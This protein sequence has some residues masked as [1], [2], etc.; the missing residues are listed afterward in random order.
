MAFGDR[1][2]GAAARALRRVTDALSGTAE[3]VE[4][5][6]KP[7]RQ[8]AKKSRKAARA[9]RKSARNKEVAR[10]QRT[11]AKEQK[12]RARKAP[13]PPAA[14]GPPA[15]PPAGPAPPRPETLRGNPVYA[16][17]ENERSSFATF[18][19]AQLARQVILDAG[20]P[21]YMVVIRFVPGRMAPFV[22]YVARRS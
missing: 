3:R 2:R 17:P 5:V 1:L 7:E 14:P 13:P 8:Q 16:T 10:E 12:R 18:E 21:A 11:V 4:G 9:Q 22:I 20:V 19:Q 6:P 15:R